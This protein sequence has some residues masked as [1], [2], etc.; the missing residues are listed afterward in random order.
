MKYN[1]LLIFSLL[2]F[3]CVAQEV[4]DGY[5]KVILDGKEVYMSIETGE[6][7]SEISKKEDTVIESSAVVENSNMLAHIVQKGETLYAISRKY[8]LS[9][10]TLLDLNELESTNLAVGQVLKLTAT[11]KKAIS[12][13]VST[14]VYTVKK[15]DTL[16]SIAR[17]LNT[18]VSALKKLNNLESNSLAVGQQLETK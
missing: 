15:G 9:V 16:Y 8:D 11:T 10:K 12:T 17:K 14:S 7:T 4:N 2:C 13:A 3:C 6:V 1:C 5:V 18:S